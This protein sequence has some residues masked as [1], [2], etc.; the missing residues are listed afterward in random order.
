M[1]VCVMCAVIKLDHRH[2]LTIGPAIRHE[3]NDLLREHAA[4]SQIAQTG[5]IP[6]SSEVRRARSPCRQ[7]AVSPP[8]PPGSSMYA[9]PL[10]I[11]RT[12]DLLRL[13][14]SSVTVSLP[15][16]ISTRLSSVP[17]SREHRCKC[18]MRTYK[19]S[20]IGR[21]PL[22]GPSVVSRPVRMTSTGRPAGVFGDHA[23]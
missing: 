7:E 13:L 18:P 5:V 11:R 20:R 22:H 16:A 4:R 3:V 9:A 1:L 23:M 14:V 2:H 17:V 10:A 15:W 21:G 6:V 19:N 8:S 12:R